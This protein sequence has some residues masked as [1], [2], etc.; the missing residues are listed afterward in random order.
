MCRR[1]PCVDFCWQLGLY[2]LGVIVS[3]DHPLRILPSKHDIAVLSGVRTRWTYLD[4]IYDVLGWTP[5]LSGILCSPLFGTSTNIVAAKESHS[6]FDQ[7]DDISFFFGFF[8][9]GF[10]IIFPFPSFELFEV[11]V[12]YQFFDGIFQ[13]Q[14]LLVVWPMCG[15]DNT[16]SCPFC[17]DQPSLLEAFRSRTWICWSEKCLIGSVE[18]AIRGV[19]DRQPL[20]FV[21]RAPGPA[22]PFAPPRT[23]RFALV[24]LPLQRFNILRPFRELDRI[25]KPFPSIIKLMERF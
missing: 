19:L 5:S 25:L 9:R 20:L 14:H 11:P 1:E 7:F 3:I 2:H 13:C 17:F 4:P 22:V 15:I 8:L 6:V 24:I 12:T 23:R 18:Q 16:F 10:T 21:L